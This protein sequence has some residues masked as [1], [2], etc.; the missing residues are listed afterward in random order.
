MIQFLQADLDALRRH[1]EQAYPQ[2]C[3]GILLG[4]R[5]GTA[6]I[7]SEFVRCANAAPASSAA[8][9]YRVA[10]EELVR[11][12]R[13]AR[14]RGV[15]IVG[16][17]HSH[18]DHPA[19]WS[20]TDLAEAYWPGCSYVIVSVQRGRAGDTTSFLLTGEKQPGFEAE[21]VQTL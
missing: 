20:D 14:A 8:T 5:E 18:P 7:V 3:C 12:Q 2:E 15:E 4:R 21:T 13:E 1:A 16:F 9:C 6:R 11:V 17:Y 19:R 10:P